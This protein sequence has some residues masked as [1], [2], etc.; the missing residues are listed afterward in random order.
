MT[1]RG[2]AASTLSTGLDVENSKL[3][4]GVLEPLRVPVSTGGS[5]KLRGTMV[6]R[7]E[8]VRGSLRAGSRRCG[9][10][11]TGLAA[12][13]FSSSMTGSSGALSMASVSSATTSSA[14]GVGSAASS[15]SVDESASGSS[16]SA[17]LANRG[18]M[19]PVGR[20]AAEP[21]SAIFGLGA[22]TASM[23]AGLGPEPA[24]RATW[25]SRRGA[26]LAAWLA[27]GLATGLAVTAV[28]RAVTAVG[29]AAPVDMLRGC[30]LGCGLVALGF[31][32]RASLATVGVCDESTV[33]PRRGVPRIFRCAPNTGSLGGTDL[34]EASNL[35][36]PTRSWRNCSSRSPRL[37]KRRVCG[38]SSS[39]PRALVTSEREASAISSD[40]VIWRDMGVF[41][42][43]W[44][45]T[46][47][48][49]VIDR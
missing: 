8:A 7:V 21:L 9:G 14:A 35:L 15:S 22:S 25:G 19:L 33:A 29:L 47:S 6:E 1:L 42:T 26:P 12:T 32:G 2:P 34:G 4:G 27:A 23:G 37:G 36:S 10:R 49:L 18:A 43:N 24:L 20:L 16:L 46:T 38:I 44:S 3:F 48:T 45:S 39:C 28:G 11:A 17:G 41:L 40:L 5:S 30:K 13:G 31:V